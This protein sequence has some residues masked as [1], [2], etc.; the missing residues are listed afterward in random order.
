MDVETAIVPMQHRLSKPN[1]G[2]VAI[3]FLQIPFSTRDFGLWTLTLGTLW[4][5][6]L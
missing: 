5:H 1:D 4:R 6:T 3:L 2:Y